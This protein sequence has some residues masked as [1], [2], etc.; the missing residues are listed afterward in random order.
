M[1]RGLG[2]IASVPALQSHVWPGAEDGSMPGSPAWQRI[3]PSRSPHDLEGRSLEATYVDRFQN[4]Y[5]LARA[6]AEQLL[7][8]QLLTTRLLPPTDL[9]DLLKGYWIGLDCAG[10]IG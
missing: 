5:V 2:R 7:H 8:L 9:V 6:S 4:V 3:R 10:A 1:L